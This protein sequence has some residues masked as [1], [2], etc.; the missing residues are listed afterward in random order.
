MQIFI[1]NFLRFRF[2]QR[3]TS[4]I[5]L[6]IPPSSNS[7]ANISIEV[8]KD[9]L[10]KTI[11]SSAT[12]NKALLIL[13]NICS[14]RIIPAFDI[15]CK[16]IITTQHQD[17]VRQDQNTIFVPVSKTIFYIFISEVIFF[18]CISR[19]QLVSQRR[20]PFCS[21]QSPST[22]PSRNCKLFQKQKECLTCAK[23]NPCS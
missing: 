17:F 6:N 18:I 11:A 16:M 1:H 2:A 10:K 5:D 13:D 19:L 14:D 23:A 12:C 9:Y 4:N 20:K 8:M 15:G 3:L 21:L 22:H 7:S